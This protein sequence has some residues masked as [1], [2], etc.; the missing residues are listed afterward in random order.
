VIDYEDTKV[1]AELIRDIALERVD[2]VARRRGA[3]AISEKISNDAN[4][5]S[6]LKWLSNPTK[7]KP[8]PSF[9]DARSED[10]EKR[11]RKCN[12]RSIAFVLK[13]NVCNTIWIRSAP[14]HYSS[15]INAFVFGDN[16]AGK[17]NILETPLKSYQSMP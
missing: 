17:H 15:C 8:S 12:L 2:I 1:L 4:V 13:R 3:K 16:S 14:I 11:L 5:E 10:R 6:L 7:R 9:F